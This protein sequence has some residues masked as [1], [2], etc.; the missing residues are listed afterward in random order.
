MQLKCLNILFK[1]YNNNQKKEVI[2]LEINKIIKLKINNENLEE[3]EKLLAIWRYSVWQKRKGINIEDINIPT[4]Y[5][6]SLK[7]FNNFEIPAFHPIVFNTGFSIDFENNTIYITHPEKK[8][9]RISLKIDEEDMEYLKKEINNGAKVTEIMIIPSS[10]LKGKHK[11][12]E[13]VKNKHWKLHITLKKNVELLT[14]EEFKKF[15]RIAVLGADLNSKYG[16]AYSLW[17]WNK[18][19]NSMKP[20][21]TR[22]LPKMKSHQFQ[23]IEKWK[24]QMN[25]R[26][27]VKYNELFQRINAK[28][29]RQNIAWI[30][31]MSKM[32]IDIALESIKEFNCEIAIISFEKLKNYK[33]GNNSKKIN[34]IN[35]EWLRGR[36]IKRTFEKSLWINSMKILTYLPTFNKNQRNLEQILIDADY[37]SIN[38]SRCGNKEKKKGEEFFC[39]KCRFTDNIHINAARNIAKRTIEYL[40]TIALP[41]TP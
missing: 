10:Y 6:N 15:Q 5:K 36:I 13:I 31:K 4:T 25:H 7:Q 1:I 39:S 17:I 26:N 40:K 8:Y 23:E 35:T 18:K 19:E 29:R 11:R 30:E 9:H 12:R 16:V 28:I 37:T 32:L 2:I 41:E 33:A 34:K 21:R 24:L 3:L 14:K 20:M 38:C 22:F 27:S